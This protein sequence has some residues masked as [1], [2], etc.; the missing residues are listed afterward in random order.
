MK[1]SQ[2]VEEIF[3]MRFEDIYGRYQKRR[4]TCEEAAELLGV[5]VKTFYRKRQRYEEEG[6]DG[7]FDSENR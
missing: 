6:F 1:K 3:K 4:L 7:K 2:L 5:S